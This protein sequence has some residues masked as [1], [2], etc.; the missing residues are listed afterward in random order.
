MADSALGKP[1]W[2]GV[3][4]CEAG[5]AEI[6]RAVEALHGFAA[7]L[8]TRFDRQF[9]LLHAATLGD[10]TVLSFLAEHNPEALAALRT[11]FAEARERGL[12]H[13][14]RSMAPAR[15]V[16]KTGRRVGERG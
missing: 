4:V 10:E 12:W 1:T 16:S 9:D 14:R 11:R 15:T 7:T 13:A 2:A 3:C 8:P 5:A 6:T